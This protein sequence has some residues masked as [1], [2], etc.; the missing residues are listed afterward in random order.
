MMHEPTVTIPV[1]AAGN[2]KRRQYLTTLSLK[3]ILMLVEP[4][5]QQKTK[6]AGLRE[7]PLVARKIAAI[8]AHRGEVESIKPIVIA[9]DRACRFKPLDET[10]N[11]G[12]GML[13][14]S[15][16]AFLDVCDGIQRI[17][18]LR[19]TVMKN[20]DLAATDW[21]VQLIETNG[22]DDLAAVV[23]MIQNQTNS[24]SDRLRSS[25]CVPTSRSW[26]T[27]VITESRLLRRAIDATKSSLSTRSGHL[28]T[29]SAMTKAL[30][31]VVG[32]DILQSTPEHASNLAA[33][34]DR[35]PA[36]ISALGDYVEGRRLAS[37][38]RQDTI[39]SQAPTV[40]ALTTLLAHTLALPETEQT[41]VLEKL[42]HY[43]WTSTQQPPHILRRLELRKDRTSALLN[44]CGLQAEPKHNK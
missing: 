28:W 39:L 5:L 20:A 41:A 35:L 15:W 10:R 16:S 43:D 23:T 6:G 9:I 12:A 2:A 14:C 38:L 21:P 25:K 7:N 13:E 8:W 33:L 4:I 29:G 17:A 11:A 3:S 42:G 19:I 27:S 40:H 24:P 22:K 31:A 32:C 36:T 34:W 37:Q 26:V 1:L 30:N 44:F 18:A